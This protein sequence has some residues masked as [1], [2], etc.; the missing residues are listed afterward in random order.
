MTE[1]PGVDVVE[2]PVTTVYPD[3]PPAAPE[4]V[5]EPVADVP[6][7]TAPDASHDPVK[8]VED[9]PSENVQYVTPQDT[10]EALRLIAK[11]K[12]V[13]PGDDADTRTHIRNL[14]VEWITQ[15]RAGITSQDWETWYTT[16]D[17]TEDEGSEDPT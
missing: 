5:A 17:N 4:P 9:I 6:E 8:R 13:Q 10:V 12:L 15:K 16:P 14:V 11:M 1:N 3:A 2:T 7:A